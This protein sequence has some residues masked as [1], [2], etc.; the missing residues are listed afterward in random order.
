M[1][2]RRAAGRAAAQ[3]AD[4]TAR[5]PVRIRTDDLFTFHG[6]GMDSGWLCLRG[7]FIEVTQGPVA[8]RLNGL[9]F[10]FPAREAWLRVEPGDYSFGRQW[11]GITGTSS[12]RPAY[13]SVSPG[14]RGA[15]EE[16]WHALIAAGARRERP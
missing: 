1:F 16:L 4:V 5:W 6:P 7:D 14:R 10:S 13:V 12:G 8:R 11:L 3:L 9:E 15:V 2:R